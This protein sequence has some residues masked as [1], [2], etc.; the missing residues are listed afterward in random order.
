MVF[1]WITHRKLVWP[2]C[3][4]NKKASTLINS[5]KTSCFDC[6]RKFFV[7]KVKRDVVPSIISGEELYDVVS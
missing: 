3:M 7:G 4:E 2:Y 6:H 1:G 5:S